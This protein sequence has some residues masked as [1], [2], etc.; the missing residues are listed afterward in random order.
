MDT[1]TQ[2]EEYNIQEAQKDHKTLYKKYE[3]FYKKTPKKVLAVLNTTKSLREKAFEDWSLYWFSEIQKLSVLD[4]NKHRL[5]EQLCKNENMSASIILEQ[6]DIIWRFDLLSRNKSIPISF[7]II[8]WVLFNW[9]IIEV[10]IRDDLTCNIIL[11]TKDYIDWDISNY[12][13]THYNISYKLIEYY[14]EQNNY[15]VPYNDYEYIIDNNTFS[16]KQLIELKL[17]LEYII[18]NKKF[19]FSDIKKYHE[20]FNCILGYESDNYYIKILS[21][22]KNITIDIIKANP[23]INW[24]LKYI[25]KNPNITEEYIRE[26]FNEYSKQFENTKGLSCDYITACVCELLYIKHISLKLIREL[27]LDDYIFNNGIEIIFGNIANVYRTDQTSFDNLIELFDLHNTSWPEQQI[28]ININHLSFSIDYNVIINNP[29]IKLKNGQEYKWDSYTILSQFRSN[30]KYN[31]YSWKN[32]EKLLSYN[33]ITLE[34]IYTNIHFIVHLINNKEIF[35]KYP[36]LKSKI[37]INIY[38]NLKC[39]KY[40]DVKDNSET[41]SDY[42]NKNVRYYLYNTNITFDEIKKDK[43][44]YYECGLT[45]SEN[46]MDKARQ[47]YI[48][49]YIIGKFEELVCYNPKYK[50]CNMILNRQYNDYL[51]NNYLDYN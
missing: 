24:N 51:D 48:D 25:Y 41:R 4:N 31:K 30:K 3:E 47:E 38:Y 20:T 10:S 7:I 44:L 15:I 43:R 32:I 34:N 22:H 23:N 14:L 1:K 42:T 12:I 46:N 36:E 8:T 11:A 5:I 50:P 39:F 27:I 9:S 29:V 13:K 28:Y 2:K 6:P 19:Y 17:P 21:R 49:N 33:I 45:L 26:T 16:T 40:E 37:P 35:N 18:K